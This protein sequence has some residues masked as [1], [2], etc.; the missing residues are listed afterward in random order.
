MTDVFKEDDLLTKA[1]EGHDKTVERYRRGFVPNF[2]EGMKKI[3]R[4]MSR[5]YAFEYPDVSEMEDIEND[6]KEFIDK[7][8][9][10][11]EENEHKE[12]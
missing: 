2:L 10:E 3:I 7:V 5:Q 11:I 6:L 1:S 12:E 9:E 4:E 8:N